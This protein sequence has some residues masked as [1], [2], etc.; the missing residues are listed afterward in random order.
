[1]N[2]EKGPEKLA[3]RG[4]SSEELEKV[5]D[6]ASDMWRALRA[7]LPSTLFFAL[8][9]VIATIGYV[10][11][12]W[13]F[14][15]A[16][17]M[18][19]ITVFS[20][21]F[22]ETQPVDTTA[23]RVWTMLVIIGGWAGVVVTLGGITKSV[24]EGELRRVT[25]TIRKTRVMEHLHDH[26]I[27]CGYGRIGQTLAREL[28]AA[29]IAFVIIDRDEE[30]V[31]QIAVE[32]YLSFKGD[33]TEEATLRSV[34]IERARVLATVLPQDALNVFITLTARDLSRE[35]KIIARGEQPST[36]KK[37]LQAG[38]NEVILPATIGGLRIAHSITSPEVAE[39]LEGKKGLDLRSLGVEI[40]EL[41]LHSHSHLLGKTVREIQKLGNGE[42]M[43]LGLRRDHEVLRENLENLT[44]EEGDALIAISRTRKLPEVIGRDVERTELL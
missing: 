42:I 26:V 18:V 11:L 8:V 38:A 4:L 21:G 19:I 33:A 32:G 37:L 6:S 2:H 10:Q 17:Y 39:M 22:G 27:I 40:D 35:I 25:E 29:K 36:E 43:V 1:M 3:H 24:T 41:S 30:R 15:D 28:T 23:E 5:R 34:G 14:F 31:A 20:V 12:G 44:L 13:P 7:V 9:I 16:L